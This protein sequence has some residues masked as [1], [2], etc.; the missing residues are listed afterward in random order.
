MGY[1]VDVIVKKHKDKE[2]YMYYEM[3]FDNKMTHDEKIK[4]LGFKLDNKEWKLVIN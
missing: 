4:K 2:G 1:G 3:I